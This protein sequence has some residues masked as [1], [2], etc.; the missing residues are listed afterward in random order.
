M[1]R[2]GLSI[3][4]K[5]LALLITVSLVTLGLYLFLAVS[6]FKDDKL[7]YVF[8][9]GSAVAR[10]LSA[11]TS[12]DLNGILNSA[13]PVIQE[14]AQLG[15]FGSVSRAIFDSDAPIDWV[16]SF[17]RNSQGKFEKDSASEKLVGSAERD[18]QSFGDLTPLMV[19]LEQK[20]KIIK[21]IDEEMRVGSDRL[22]MELN[23][24]TEKLRFLNDFFTR[25]KVAAR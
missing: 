20:E 21:D 19:E 22:D 13:K 9:S 24:Q 8:E 3:K 25:G 15:K 6:I 7:A 2:Q 4:Y 5:I 16:V 11:Q 18:L 17:V 14:Y 23:G 1:N 12:A 10:T